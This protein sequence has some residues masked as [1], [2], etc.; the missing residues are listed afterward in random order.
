VTF[1]HKLEDHDPGEKNPRTLESYQHCKSKRKAGQ[2]QYFW[3]GTIGGEKENNMQ[4]NELNVIH[5]TDLKR[6]EVH[7]DSHIAE[8]KYQL[9]GGTIVFTHTGV[10]P[11]LEGRGIGSSLV[12]TGLEYAKENN[13]KVQALCWFVSGYLQ[14]HPEYQALEK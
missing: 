8:L 6:F 10:P 7:F 1:Q 5:N 14:R 11:A 4:K 3:E 12:K 2:C 9:L 13:L